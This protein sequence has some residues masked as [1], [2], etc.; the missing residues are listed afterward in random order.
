MGVIAFTAMIGSVWAN[1]PS[2]E[3]K[4]AGC[5]SVS[6]RVG[7]RKGE[8]AG[9]VEAECLNESKG[10]RKGKETGRVGRRRARRDKFVSW[11]T[12]NF[13]RR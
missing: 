10:V 8:A 4:M 7:W 11:G 12:R 1:Y 9:H 3:A 2:R 6:W 13:T 5:S